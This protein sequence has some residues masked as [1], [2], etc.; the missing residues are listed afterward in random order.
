M[1]VSPGGMGLVVSSGAVMLG[2]GEVVT[3]CRAGIC[4]SAIVRR[5]GRLRG[6]PLIGVSFVEAGADASSFACP[7][8]LPAFAVA[9]SPWFDRETLRLRVVAVDAR[10]M[11]VRLVSAASVP[12]LG[13][14]E[15]DFSLHLPCIGV[16]AARSHRWWLRCGGRRGVVR[17]VPRALA[18][19]RPVPAGGDA[20]LTPMA[21]RAAGLSVGSV[22]NA[23]AYDYA[24]AATDFEEVLALRLRAHQAIGHLEAASVDDMRSPF[25]GFSRHLVCRFG[26]G[27]SA[28]CA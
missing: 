27:S 7:D 19:H 11:T 3:L 26:G 18:R 10:G 1:D 24:T 8:E 22:E 16:I 9:P 4:V 23:V 13:G 28:T 14:M 6:L 2:I 17:A 15:L 21:L 12:L 25:D 20:S 5:A